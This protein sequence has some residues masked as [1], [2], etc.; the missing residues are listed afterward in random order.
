MHL[1]IKTVSP[2]L[3]AKKVEIP[4]LLI[5]SK[6]DTV[7][8]FKN[9]LLLQQAISHN[10]DAKVIFTH[11]GQHGEHF[12]NYHTSIEAFYDQYLKLRY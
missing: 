12:P 5:H 6:K 2:L 3:A 11:S 10:S 8:P 1:D 4:V 9:A 7:V